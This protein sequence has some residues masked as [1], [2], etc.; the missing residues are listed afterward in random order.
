MIQERKDNSIPHTQFT[1]TL[2]F[3][4]SNIE[5]CYC[6]T[7]STIC[8][9]KSVLWDAGCPFLPLELTFCDCP[10]ANKGTLE[11]KRLP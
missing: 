11:P 6:H 1:D 5:V 2:L 3:C 4:M 10:M 9:S 7:K 8:P